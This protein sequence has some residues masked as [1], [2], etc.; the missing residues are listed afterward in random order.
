MHDCE[1]VPDCQTN[2]SQVCRAVGWLRCKLTLTLRQAVWSTGLED[3]DLDEEIR[4]AGTRSA[5]P[6]DAVNGCKRIRDLVT[7]AEGTLRVRLRNL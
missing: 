7:K 6:A 2:A 4:S 3:S 5:A 1:S